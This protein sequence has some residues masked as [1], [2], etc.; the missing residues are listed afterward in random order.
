MAKTDARGYT[1]TFDYDAR[2]RLTQS[3]APNGTTIK[4]AYNPAGRLVVWTDPRGFRTELTY[5]PDGR[6]IETRDPLGQVFRR[7]YDDNGL[8]TQIMDERGALT[9]YQFDVLNRL[10]QI[11]GPEGQVETLDYDTNGNLVRATRYDVTDLSD[12]PADPRLLPDELRRTLTLTYDTLNRLTSVTDPEGNRITRTYDAAGNV[13]VVTD[14]RQH[15]LQIS[16]DRTNRPI[17]ITRPDGGNVT[18]TYDEIG[19]RT[20]LITPDGGR[21]QWTYN[22]R[23]RVATAT[24]PLGLATTFE[25]DAVGNLRRQLNP[26]GSWITGDFDALNRRQ[27]RARSDGSFASWAYDPI[28]NIIKAETD[29]TSLELTYDEL[30]RS[31]SETLT[32]PGTPFSK[33]V[34]FAY[35]TTGN[36]SQI[37]DPTGREVHY[38]Y[39]LARRLTQVET[40]DQGMVADIAHNSFGE[41]TTINFGNQTT[42]TFAYDRNGQTTEI[43][44]A[45]SLAELSYTYDPAHNPQSITETI[46][47][48]TEALTIEYDPLN[49]PTM[50]QAAENPAQHAERFAYDGNGNL[51]MPGAGDTVTFNEADQPVA[52][53]ATQYEH[54][55]QGNLTRVAT[56]DL[57]QLETVYNPGSRLRVRRDFSNGNLDREVEYT[58]DALGRIAEIRHDMSV[59]RVVHA[60]NHRLVEFDETDTAQVKYITGPRLDDTFAVEVAGALRYVHRD[61]Q[62]NV[63]MT[64]DANGA[65]VSTRRYGQFG[66]LL[67]S[68]G[69]IEVPLGYVGRPVDPTTGLIDLR[70]RWYDPDLGRFLSRDPLKPPPTS[71]NAYVYAM[72]RP[73]VL[74]DPL[75]LVPGSPNPFNFIN[76]F[77]KCVPNSD[78]NK[79]PDP[80]PPHTDPPPEGKNEDQIEA[81]AQSNPSPLASEQVEDAHGDKPD[82]DDEDGNDL[83][84]KANID[85]L[86]I[87][88]ITRGI[89]SNPTV[90]DHLF[91]D[92]T[93]RNIIREIFEGE[94]FETIKGRYSEH[95]IEQF[96]DVGIAEANRRVEEFVDN[97]T[98]GL[99]VVAIAGLIVYTEGTILTAGG[100][101]TAAGAGA[102]NVITLSPASSAASSAGGQAAAAITATVIATSTSP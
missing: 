16:Y 63:R 26:D 91:P 83:D 37:T 54:D 28:G 9:S 59:T 98:L 71:P 27:Y 31:T 8:L 79:P 77:K 39:N 56:A 33:I 36:L 25:Y 17:Q 51:V 30:N 65:V 90:Q 3:T 41:R 92:P 86:N 23:N 43:V 7:G 11:R 18:M 15:T 82:L 69:T 21:Y 20:Q 50:V 45:P 70:A 62:N 81:C 47:G 52:R 85:D 53:G 94:D 44:Y 97:A 24:D 49:R 40:S 101:T 74:N 55:T 42:G 4:R 89:L 87:D 22:K 61:A 88:P 96:K 14:P 10:T 76:F 95:Q 66:R 68:T 73:Q 38:T 57:S 32:F 29:K 84:I 12:I 75:G 48:L 67:S 80:D 46:N 99:S 58:Y 100:G 5:D 35:D 72:N 93:S 78:N 34:R 13:I 6:V 2:N 60:F 64:T 19:N 102:S 1:F